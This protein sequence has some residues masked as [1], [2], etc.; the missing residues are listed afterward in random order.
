M[1]SNERSG[2]DA[3]RAFDEHVGHF[4]PAP[5]TASVRPIAMLNPRLISF[6][7]P[8]WNEES[9]LRPMLEA[10]SAARRHLTEPSEVIVVDDSSTDQT[11]EIA[12]RHGARVV[13]VRDRQISA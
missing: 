8:A 4:G 3:G 10:L 11:A 9:V 2:V 1:K 13:S 7:I 5:L 6:V 12:R